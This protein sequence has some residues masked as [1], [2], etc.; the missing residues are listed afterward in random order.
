MTLELC[1]HPQ[2]ESQ[3]SRVETYAA[4]FGIRGPELEIVR[5]WVDEGAE[6]ATEDYDRFY[7]EILRSSRNLTSA[8]DYLVL[9]SPDPELA[10]RLELLHDLPADTLGYATSSSTAETTLC[11]PARIRTCRR[12]T[13]AT[14]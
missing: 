9:T 5:R 4:A 12:T 8:R 1:R 7:A 11:C 2:T 6:R 14:T 3:I 10:R 13:S